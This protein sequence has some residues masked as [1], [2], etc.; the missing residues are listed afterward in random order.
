MLGEWFLLFTAVMDFG[1]G[2][3]S[4]NGNLGRRVCLLRLR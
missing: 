4:A 3:G 1:M 2:V